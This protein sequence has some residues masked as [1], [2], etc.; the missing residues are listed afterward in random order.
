MTYFTDLIVLSLLGSKLHF[1]SF[2][3]YVTKRLSIVE[4]CSKVGFITE[5]ILK[6]NFAQKKK[7]S[8]GNF[9]IYQAK[10]DSPI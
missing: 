5:T 9:Y 2:T 4:N 3:L 8:A 7:Y 6:D 1:H 10:C